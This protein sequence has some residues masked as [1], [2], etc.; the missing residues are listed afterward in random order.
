MIGGLESGG[1]TKAP[2]PQYVDALLCNGYS[3]AFLLLF[4][5]TNTIPHGVNDDGNNNNIAV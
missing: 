3:L 4:T 5:A 2:P 1:E